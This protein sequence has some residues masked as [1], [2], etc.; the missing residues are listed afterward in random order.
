ELTITLFSIDPAHF[1]TTWPEALAV[2]S[3]VRVCIAN[4]ELRTWNPPVDGER[5]PIL[6]VSPVPTDNYGC[7]G[8]RV[9]VKVG[10]MLEGF[11]RGRVVR[12]LANG[13]PVK[14]QF[15]GESLM[16]YGYGKLK[17]QELLENPAKEYPDQVPFRTDFGNEHLP[18]FR[19]QDGVTPP[20]FAEHQVLGELVTADPAARTGRFRMDRTGELAD[21]TLVPKG[22]VR[23]LNADSSLADLPTGVRYRFNLFQDEK[24]AFT[25]AALIRDEFSR[26]AAN[27]VTYRVEAFHQ[28]EGKLRVAWQIPEVKNYNGDMERPPDIG[29]SEFR[30][31]PETR[32]WKGVKDAQ[33]ADLTNLVKGVNLLINV[34]GEQPSSP[35]R[36]TDIWIDPP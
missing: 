14:D 32:V 4:D 30:V 33:P 5:G 12:I 18:W 3:D 1:K 36:C 35:S 23:F 28:A 20:P 26:L 22:T 24:G 15:Y 2:K 25:R 29:R 17:N 7:S 11:R 31:T 27:T 10:N 9:K 8:F 13:W 34:T 19:L 6:E 16:G 21:F